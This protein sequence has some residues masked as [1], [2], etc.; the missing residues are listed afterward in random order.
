MVQTSCI[1]APSVGP[2]AWRVG[3]WKP[4]QLIA[5]PCPRGR[6]R[7]VQD[8]ARTPWQ[9]RTMTAKLAM[10]TID[11]DDP[12]TLAT[13]YSELLGREV[14]HSSDDYAMITGEGPAIG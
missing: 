7:F 4:G 5:R 3:R 9:P 8:G 1:P 10:F 14:A 2:I 11:C 6:V 12:A 13:F